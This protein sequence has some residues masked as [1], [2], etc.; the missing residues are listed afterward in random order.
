MTVGEAAS[1][2]GTDRLDA[3]LIVAHV[4]KKDRTWVIAHPEKRIAPVKAKVITSMLRRRS[5]SEPLAYILGTKDFYGHSFIV[6]KDTLIPR[7]ATEGLIELAIDVLNN[8]EGSVVRELDTDI[9]GVASIWKSTNGCDILDI[10]TGS[11]CIAVTLKKF[12]PRKTVLATDISS[13]A[14][15]IA[16]RNAKALHAP[17]ILKKGDALA[18]FKTLKKPFL[19]VSNPPYI[20]RGMKLMQDVEKFEPKH[21]LFGGK[22]GIDVIR[23]IL[24]QAKA[25]PYCAGVV[26]ECRAN[27]ASAF[28]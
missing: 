18:P 28:D 20:P 12:F 5:K 25:H 17:V 24:R 7:P 21:A 6:T 8:K 4:L 27:Q 14:L 2:P 1:F 15:A 3:E 13:K 9:V 10:G 26:I 16:K 23:K 22:E 11:G 19:I